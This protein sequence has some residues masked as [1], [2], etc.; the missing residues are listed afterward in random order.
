MRMVGRNP[1]NQ[2][3]F[4][5]GDSIAKLGDSFPNTGES[6]TIPRESNQ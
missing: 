2:L 3:I 4:L 1:G 6:L 5:P